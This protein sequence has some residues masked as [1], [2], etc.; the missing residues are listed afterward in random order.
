[1][2]PADSVKT[3][4]EEFPTPYDITLL[5]AFPHMHLIGQTI[6]SYGVLPTGDTDNYVRVNTWDFHWQGFYMFPRFKKAAT[7]TRLRAEA[8]YNNTATNPNNPYSPPQNI[9]V[10]EN[11]TNEMMIVFFVYTGYQPGDENIIVDS[12]ILA[13]PNVQNTNYYHGQQLLDVC[14]NPAVS[15]MVV[16]CFMVDPDV[17]SMELVDMQGQVVRRYMTNTALR[18]GYSAFTYSVDGISPGTYTLVIRTSQQVL[19]KK[20]VVMH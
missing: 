9:S 14:P 16:K 20:V 2:I 1:M 11:T 18:E 19:T 10:G 7:G 3:F 8:T 17:A 15:S 13:S 6:K 12:T 5:G 4:Q